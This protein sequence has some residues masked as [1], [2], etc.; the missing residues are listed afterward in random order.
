MWKCVNVMNELLFPDIM[1]RLEE[2][3]NFHYIHSCDLKSDVKIKVGNLEGKLLQPDYE[4]VIENPILRFAGR[5]QSRVPDLLVSVVVR[6][7]STSLHIPVTTAYKNFTTRWAWN[8]WLTLP[9]KFCELPHDSLL[10][11]TI[12][13]CNG[14]GER[15]AIGGTSISLFG[16]KGMFRTGQMDLVVWQGVAGGEASPGKLRDTD[17]EQYHRL[18][19]LSKKYHDGK[20]PPVDWLDR[21][22]FAEIG[23]ISQKDK[24]ASAKLYL[25]IE[26]PHT[27][28]KDLPISVVY[29]ELGPVSVSPPAVTKF[30]PL[31]DPDIGHDNLIEAKHHKVARSARTGLSE[32]DLRP[33]PDTRDRLIYILHTPVTQALS[34][35]ELDL[36]WRFRYYLANNKKAL[37]KFVKCVKWDVEVEAEQAMEVITSHWVPIDVEDALELVGPNWRHPSLRRYAVSRLAQASDEDLQMYLLQL[38]QAIKYDNYIAGE[39]KAEKRRD[40]NQSDGEHVDLSSFLITRASNHASLANYLYWYLQIET[41]EEESFKAD[42]IAMYREVLDNFL[43]VT[44]FKETLEKQKKFIGC[45]VQLVSTVKEGGGDRPKMIERMKQLLTD[46]EQFNINFTDFEPL[47]LPLDPSISVCGIKP[48]E[49]TLFKSSLMPAR[50]TFTTETED[51]VAI[52][53]N[54]D[55]LRQDQLILQIISLMDKLLRRENLDLKLSPYQALATSSKHGFVQFVDAIGIADI[56]KNRNYGS[57]LNFFR[58]H[59]PCETG[60][61][62]VTADC[63]DNYVKSCAGYCVITYLLGVGDRHLDNLMLTKSGNLVHIDFGFILGRDPKPL[64]PPMKLSKQMIEGFGDGGMNSDHYQEF[65]KECHTAFII[66]RKNA[67]LI[68]NLFGLMVDANIPD[69]ALEPDKAVKKVEDKFRLDLTEEEAVQFMEYLIDKSATAIMAGV[70]E[71]FHEVAQWAR[72]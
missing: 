39:K 10:C 17:K 26:F 67:S 50:L 2:N 5:N 34:S 24:S 14:P 30:C 27:M 70:M 45:L 31:P 51:Y 37:S 20:I 28:D 23:R 71:I 3:S 36:L 25:N 65:K 68:L 6:T 32:R 58:K 59:N 62:G 21:I 13:D 63:M 35:E 15:E 7:G 12:W 18:A 60:P 1:S 54:G 41:D 61:Y 53:K 22:T 49:V 48:S 66:L 40:R 57:I 56:L 47:P 19:K 46:T 52:F 29:F 38:V 42:N 72:K 11:F 33:D 43:S 64:P 44:P 9:I 69:I 16:K 4:Q 8:Q 55:D